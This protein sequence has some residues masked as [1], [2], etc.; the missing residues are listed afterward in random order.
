MKKYRVFIN[1]QNFLLNFDDRVQKMG[2]YTTRFVEAATP[3]DA[4]QAAIQ[5][6]REGKLNGIVLN[7]KGDP[8]MLYVDEIVEVKKLQRDWGLGFYP[9]N[10]SED[11]EG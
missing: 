11:D 7:E 10:E 9:E 8:A 5:M 6:M 2:F 3:E 4:E 1:G